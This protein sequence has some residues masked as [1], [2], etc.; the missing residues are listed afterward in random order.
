MAF[1]LFPSREY[2]SKRHS[3]G[4]HV[5]HV[6]GGVL[7]VGAHPLAEED[8]VAVPPHH[9]GQ[10]EPVEVVAGPVWSDHGPGAQA[11]QELQQG[12]LA[13]SLDHG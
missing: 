8:V 1:L 13:S 10:V 6:H 11:V 7:A 12:F 4:T 9:R 2:M 3:H 5:D